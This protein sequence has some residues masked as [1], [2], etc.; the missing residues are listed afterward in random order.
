MK[1][2]FTL[3]LLL[4]FYFLTA[5]NISYV[6]LAPMPEKVTNNAV[7]AATVNGISYVYSFSGI[8]ST[9]ACGNNHLKSFRYNN[10]GVRCG[11]LFPTR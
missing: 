7:T 1:P 4:L 10:R 5:Q 11:S 6:D 9:K 8:D 3:F 2:V